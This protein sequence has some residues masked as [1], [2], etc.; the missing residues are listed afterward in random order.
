[1]PKKKVV[2]TTEEIVEEAPIDYKEDIQD[3]SMEEIVKETPAKEEPKEEEKEKKEEEP[4]PEIDQEKLKEEV[5]E[6]VTKKIIKSLTGKTEDE[7]TEEMGDQSPWAKEGRNPKDYD[8]IANWSVELVEKKNEAKRVE[9]EK[10]AAETKATQEVTATERATSFNKYWDEQLED[11]QESGKLPKAVD[12]TDENDDGVIARKELFKTM[13]DINQERVKEGKD[14]I[15]SL[16]E[17]YYEHYTPKSKQPAGAD[18]PISAGRSS[19]PSGDDE[20]YEYVGKKSWADI[21]F[22]RQFGLL[23]QGRV[24]VELTHRIN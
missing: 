4:K 7:A 23:T 15:Y 22:K 20:A 24:V 14:P 12:T 2:T 13:L 21:I 9:V 1:M 18:A 10:T 11:L 3:K 17:V 16:K 19:A 5:A 6:E 8:E